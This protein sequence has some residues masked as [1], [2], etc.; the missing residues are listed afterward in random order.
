MS[1]DVSALLAPGVLHESEGCLVWHSGVLDT[2]AGVQFGVA[3]ERPVGAQPA[4][5]LAVEP[6]ARAGMI[7]FPAA[8]NTSDATTEAIGR[9]PVRD[10]LEERSV[11]AK[12]FVTDFGLSG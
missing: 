7:G 1:H 4:T 9:G 6:G 2:P 11:P 5:V 10:G 3:V 12:T 8:S